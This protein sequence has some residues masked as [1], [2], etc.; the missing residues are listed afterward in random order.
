MKKLLLSTK[1][2]S[3]I[4]LLISLIIISL[5]IGAFAPIIT[6]KLKA[7]DVTVGSS[8][9]AD[10]FFTGDKCTSNC[11]L[12]T[13]NNCLMCKTGYVK[14]GTECISEI[15]NCI[16]YK[17]ESTCLKCK[18]GYILLNGLCHTPIANCTSYSD[19]SC[20]SCDLGYTRYNGFCAKNITNCISYSDANTCS[21]C[22]DNYT[23][24]SNS[25]ILSCNPQTVT[26][27]GT[28]TKVT[29][30]NMG[31][32][33]SYPRSVAEGISGVTFV[34]VG[35]KCEGELCCW[36][37]VTAVG[38]TCTNVGGIYSGCNRTV[39]KWWAAKKICE[40]IGDGWKLPD[41]SNSMASW[42]PNNSTASTGLMLC[43]YIVSGTSASGC[44]GAA[45]CPGSYN[46]YCSPGGVWARSESGGSAQ[47]RDL[48]GG[49]WGMKAFDKS[50]AFSVRCVKE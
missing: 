24:S 45:S 47:R 7:S 17:N 22:I 37:G 50:Y 35:T 49:T 10:E 20:S 4:E 26:L 6:K 8:Y 9:A 41:T 23:L 16:S 19:G 2:F 3:L 13:Q 46:G 34:P 28:N 42:Y 15:A 11:A 44:A 21:K 43:D 12:C 48:G 31:D 30:F 39:C 38:N 18:D 5:L 14:Y 32:D 1:A 27:A 25:C 40:S 29:R 36:Y 33:P